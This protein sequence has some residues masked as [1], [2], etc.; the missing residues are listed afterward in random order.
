MPANDPP[1]TSRS[2]LCRLRDW[3]DHQA[4]ITFLKRY[5]AGIQTTCRQAGLGPAAAEE[6]E[7]RVLGKLPRRLRVFVY[8]PSRTFR[9]WLRRLVR[10]EAIDYYR[11][12]ARDPVGPGS[13]DSAVQ[14]WLEQQHV[15]PDVPDAERTDQQRQ[16][17]ELAA[18][19]EA[20]VRERVTPECWQAFCLA[21]IEGLST[22]EAAAKLGKTFAVTYMAAQ[23]VR[24][25]LRCEGEKCLAEL[26]S[27]RSIPVD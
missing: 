20:A 8:D 10:R 22:K 17:R 14:R 24:H 15:A 21:Y 3:R 2:L 11:L 7:L 5:R 18:R 12:M 25:R 13:G 16:L 6:V 19:V 4:W 9:G 26:R 23:R 1:K 27:R